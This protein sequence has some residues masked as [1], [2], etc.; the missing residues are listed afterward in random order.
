MEPSLSLAKGNTVLTSAKK[1]G[2]LL[3]GFGLLMVLVSVV[4]AE[5]LSPLRYLVIG[6]AS[7]TSGLFIMTSGHLNSET[8]AL[9]IG[10]R[11]GLYLFGAG[12]FFGLVALAGVGEMIPALSFWLSTGLVSV[13]ATYYSWKK[14]GVDLPGIRNNGLKRSSAT[15]R[16]TLGWLL[17]VVFTGFYVLIY[18]FPSSLEGLIRTMDPLSWLIRGEGADQWFM[19]G[20]FYTLAVL[21]MGFRAMLKYRHDRYQLIRTTSVMFFQL[22]F[23]FIIPNL[24]AIFNQPEFYFHYFWPL[25]YQYLWPGSFGIGWILDHPGGLGMLMIFWGG[26]MTV[27]VTPVLTYFFGKRWYCSWVC[28]CGGLAET[29]GDPWRHLS[30]KSLRAWQIERW[31]IHSVL[32]VIV[33]GTLVLWVNS[34]LGG[35]L[36]GQISQ[37]FSRVYGFLIGSVFAGVIGVGFYPV[38]GSRMWCRFGCPMAAV[39]GIFQKYFSRFR[40]T[41]NGSQCIS[42]GNCSTH[43]EMGIDVRWYAQRGQNIVRSSCVGCGICSAVCP[44]GVLKLENGPRDD[45]YNG[46]VLAGPMDL[47]M[48]MSDE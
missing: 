37:T 34:A 35:V 45:R 46:D 1:L 47:T 11:R 6:I 44:R 43:C 15:A 22:G 48:L 29:L 3:V 2:L 16:G 33:V 8:T 25:K 13:G 12:L 9:T 21:V 17:G 39:L 20:A 18:W 24:L 23:A 5:V 4:G 30:N 32:T 42:C 41:T 40:I 27:V 26:I 7:A 19:Y 10:E 14:Y 38:L 28:G 31:M 36:L